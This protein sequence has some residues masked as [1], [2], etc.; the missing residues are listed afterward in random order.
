MF[1]D[2]TDEERSFGHLWMTFGKASVLVL[3]SRF[4]VEHLRRGIDF[5]SLWTMTHL[6]I[7]RESSKD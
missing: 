2:N 6:D 5:F 4:S 3:K 7:L 1:Q